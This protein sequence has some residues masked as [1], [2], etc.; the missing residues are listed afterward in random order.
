MIED[1]LRSNADKQNS[2]YQDSFEGY[3][4]FRQ[5]I[6]S[7]AENVKIGNFEEKSDLFL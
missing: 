3:K 6:I 1:R 5:Q 2:I 4:A 7:T